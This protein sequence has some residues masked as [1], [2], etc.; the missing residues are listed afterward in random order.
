MRMMENGQM[1]SAADLPTERGGFRDPVFLLAPPRSHSTVSIALLDGH[2]QLHGL[3]ET[4]VFFG[5][6]VGEIMD[7]WPNRPSAHL[8]GLRRAV[9]QLHDGS[10]DPAALGRAQAWLEQRR[11]VSTTEVM[12]HVLRL[13]YPRIAV[14]KSP[15]T[16]SSVPTLARCMRA[17]PGARYLHLTRH[18]VTS[19]RS[20]LELRSKFVPAGW[21]HDERVRRS[22][23][24][25]YTAH[26]RIIQALRVLPQRRWLRVRSEDLIG[27]PQATVPRVLN[28]LGLESDQAII[29]R[30][31]LTERWEFAA[32][33]KDLGFGA[34]DPKFLAAPHLHPVPPPEPEVIDPQWG[35]SDPIRRRITALALHLGYG[36]ELSGDDRR[37]RA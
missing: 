29:G 30:M 10:Q 32:W 12:D 31:L 23:H 9:A 33:D 35:I 37:P 18:P 17:Y 7:K 26:L 2:P 24:V 21:P 25:W 27:D 28:W 3:P 8:T 16:V 11:A 14:E 15:T 36:G 22:L 34:A 19:V 6:T 20:L 5:A 1:T 4:S 13:V